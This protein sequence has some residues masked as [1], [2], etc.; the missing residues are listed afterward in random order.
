MTFTK[1]AVVIAVKNGAETIGSCLDSIA[2]ALAEGAQ[3]YVYDSLSTDDTK[4]IVASRFPQARYVCKKDGGLYY[5]WNLAIV[6]VVEPYIFFINCDD[7]LHSIKNLC[8]ILCD[9]SEH[10]DA[11]ASSGQTIMTRIDGATR[12]AGTRLRRDWFVG[13][14][15]IVTPATI[16]SV[17][18]LRELNGFDVGYRISADYDLALRMLAR[19]GH[20]AILFSPLQILHFSLGGMSNRYRKQALS[21]VHR[22]VKI[23]LGRVKLAW[24]LLFY[25]RIEL[26]R[27]LLNMYFLVRRKT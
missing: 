12:Y 17:R 23:N 25:A 8:S 15:P 20:S 6:E 7:T 9:L 10:S 3:L 2:P 18:A 1:L 27:S 26:K 5:A 24:H 21:E 22:I 16:F 4:S 14:M 11:V 13:D 19:Y